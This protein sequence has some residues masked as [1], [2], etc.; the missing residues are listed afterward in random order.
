M[1]RGFI[2]KV[3]KTYKNIKQDIKGAE[4]YSGKTIEKKISIREKEF[5]I[6]NEVKEKEIRALIKAVSP[7]RPG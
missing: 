4:V 6:E 3:K 1:Q 5:E 2:N 7:K